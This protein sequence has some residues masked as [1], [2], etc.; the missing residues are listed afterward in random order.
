MKVQR[1]CLGENQYSWLV[2]GN[3][4][5]PIK[6]IE[7]FIR[8]LNHTEKSPHTLR[9]YANHLKLFW[10]FLVFRQKEWTEVTISDFAHFVYWLRTHA[11]NVVYL[12]QDDNAKRT[13]STVNT[14][15]AAISSFYRYHNQLGNTTIQLTEAFNLP[16]NKYKSL[17][18][19][20]FKNKP[21][22]KRIISLKQP[23]NLPQTLSQQQVTTLIEVCANSRDRFLVS[24]LYETGLRIGQALALRHT[25]IKS[26]DNEIHVIYRKNN[27]NQVRNKTL[28]ANII[29]V[30]AALMQ[31]YSE[32]VLMD[33]KNIENEYVFIN[34]LTDEPLH[35]SAIRKL[36]LRLS[37]KTGFR[38]TPHMLRH[39]HVTE[40]IRTGWDAAL[41]QKRLGHASVQTTLDTYSHVDQED[42][43]RAFQQYQANKENR[44]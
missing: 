23:K 16:V 20:I 12:Q 14:M 38:I 42:L 8:Y 41:V 32:Y 24:L 30:S 39:T 34:F 11:P 33:C 1:I 2:L 21:I 44:S 36:F 19:H 3:D 43:K 37:K 10:D 17:L 26:W 9:C 7:S 15:L 35:Y 31:L 18:Y 22:Q 25:D 28:P 13:E 5:L 27:V 4:D 6:P 29:H 40:L